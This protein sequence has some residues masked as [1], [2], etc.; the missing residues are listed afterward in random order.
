MWGGYLAENIVQA[1]SRDIL[2]EA[3]LKIEKLGVRIPL[4][5]HDDMS[6]VVPESEVDT[7]LP[8][9]EDIVRTPPAWASNLPIDIDCKTSRRYA[10]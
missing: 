2:A 9:I 3:V 10:K 4:I 6:I 1:V 7:Y 8:Q 5:V